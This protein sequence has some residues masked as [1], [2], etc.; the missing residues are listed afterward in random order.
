[1]I[2]FRCLG[3]VS[4]L[5]CPSLLPAADLPPIAE[6]FAPALAQVDETPDFQRHVMPLLGRLG[7]NGR[8]CHG[9]FQGRGGFRLSMFGYD[10]ETDHAALTQGKRP[11]IDAD[12][13][14]DSLMLAKPIDADGHGGGKRFDKN[15]WEY[16]A[17]KKWIAAGAKYDKTSTIKLQ[18]LEVT[19]HELLSRKVGEEFPVKVFAHWSDDTREDVTC[20]T[21]FSS[22]DDA[23][24]KVGE[25]GRVTVTGGGCAYI[26]STYDNGVQSNLVAL[27]ITDRIGP[28]YPQVTTRTV[29]DEKIVAHLRKLG[30]VPSETCGDADFLRRASLDITGTL[31]LPPEVLE[32]IAD[33]SP[34][35]RRKKIDE[36]LERPAY[37]A[38]W[39]TFLCDLTGLNAPQFLGG[40]EWA[41]LT[42]E[43]WQ[44]WFL[45]RVRD[46]VG[47]DKISRGLILAVSRPKGQSYADY[48]KELSQY[49]QVKNPLDYADREFLP[50]FWHRANV[51]MP[52]EKALSFAHVFLG[53]RLDCAQCHKHPFDQWSQQDFKQFSALFT[54][55]RAGVSSEA[56]VQYDELQVKL[57]NPDKQPAAERRAFYKQLSD[58]GEPAPWREVYVAPIDEKEKK[59]KLNDKLAPKIL[60]GD[61]VPP[62]DDIHPLEPLMNWLLKPDN[63]YFARA[64]V[65]RVWA[66]YFGRGIV[67]A[68]DDFNLGNPPGNKALLDYLAA[69][70]VSHGYDMKWLHREIANSDTYQRSCTPNETNALDEIHFSRAMLRRLPAEVALDATTLATL[71]VKGRA[72]WIRKV[73]E[74]R[75]AQQPT[76]DQRRT[77]FGLVVFGKPLRITNCDCEREDNPSLLQ[78]IYMRNDRD[79]LNLL[80]RKEGW[81]K[82]LTGQEEVDVL[83]REA[84]LRTLSRLPTVSESKRSEAY[85]KGAP[86]LQTGMRDLLWALLN[87][88]EFITNH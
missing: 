44:Q 43:Q 77:E 13:I 69:G 25:T 26:I 39:T 63:P 68:A 34:D 19:P 82:E 58:K 3:L 37:A 46:N 61:V 55:I 21:R 66:V 87:T 78:S 67:E 71:G 76:A 36:L 28:K 5:L 14:D 49:G 6:R 52:D 33:Q 4:L 32:F 59:K 18:R 47:Y 27:P 17:I 16:R 70:F 75:V 64:F 53:V 35:K 83:I 7:C 50:H 86:K 10:F 56:K 73:A 12:S 22:T 81:I 62:S 51:Q 15:G 38:W 65:N 1:M 79:L 8:N 30:V 84:Y 31:P 29:I 42:G 11:K 45:R 54:R 80:D 60:G 23:V 20:L 24:A 40:T 2:P 41:K 88:K 74:R 9:S 72:D 48:A 85:L 57:G